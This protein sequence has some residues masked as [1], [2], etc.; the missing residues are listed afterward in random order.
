MD[1]DINALDENQ[2]WKILDLLI[3]KIP[4]CYKWV[5]IIKYSTNGSIEK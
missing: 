5:H 1:T 3:D 2:T 4:I